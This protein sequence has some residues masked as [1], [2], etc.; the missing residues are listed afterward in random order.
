MLE[1]EIQ[2]I[3]KERD[4]VW[5]KISAELQ[6]TDLGSINGTFRKARQSVWCIPRNNVLYTIT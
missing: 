6:S 3:S 1:E 4:K 2:R 5:K